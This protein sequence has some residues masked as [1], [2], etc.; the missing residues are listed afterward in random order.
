[1]NPNLIASK[2][3]WQAKLGLPE[4]VQNMLEEKI[5]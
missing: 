1:M 5:R 3:D 4:I 2:L